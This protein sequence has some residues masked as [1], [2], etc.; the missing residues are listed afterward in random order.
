MTYKTINIIAA[1]RAMAEGDRPDM[2]EM[3]RRLRERFPE[4]S[5]DQI[6]HA[7]KVLSDELRE[8]VRE[9]DAR[10]REGQRACGEAIHIIDGLG[11]AITLDEAI[12]IKA[13]LGD[14]VALRWRA[15]MN[16]KQYRLLDALGEAAHKAHPHF[17]QTPDKIWHW[18]GNGDM[19]SEDAMIDWFQ[20]THPTEAR[21]IE[22]EIDAF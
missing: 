10:N 12:E 4:I 20:M 7:L 18:N 13:A 14:L 22:A 2:G 11:E 21:R 1:L 6:S 3:Q 16:T 19:P 5:H 9:S 8:Q 17:K 15:A